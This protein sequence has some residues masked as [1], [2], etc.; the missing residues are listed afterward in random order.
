MRD[1]SAF[2]LYLKIIGRE[3]WA[4][5]PFLALLNQPGVLFVASSG[6]IISNF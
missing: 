5:L 3:I 1:L 4:A 6:N 2:K